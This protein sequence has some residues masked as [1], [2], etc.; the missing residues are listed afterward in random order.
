MARVT[1][2]C[3][4]NKGG[5]R[6]IELARN[7]LHLLCGEPNRLRQHG[8]LISTEARL[9]EYITNVITVIHSTL[10]VVV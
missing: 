8:Q 3:G 4:K 10:R 6:E 7:L 1:G 9:G 2:L 5:F